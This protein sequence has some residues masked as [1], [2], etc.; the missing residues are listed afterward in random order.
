[1]AAYVSIERI[2][3]LPSSGEIEWIM[4][5]AS[6]AKGVLPQWMQNMAVPGQVAHDV[7]LF[8]KWIPSQRSNNSK[9]IFTRSSTYDKSLPAAP[10]PSDSASM[11]TVPPPPISKTNEAPPAIARVDSSNKALPTAPKS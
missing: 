1:M 10:V 2:R 5:T 11:A 4:A 6:D 8:L 9:P 7:D 3:I